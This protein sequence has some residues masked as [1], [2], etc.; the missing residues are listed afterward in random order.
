MARTLLM[1]PSTRRTVPWGFSR[2]GTC[3]P[4]RK[5]RGA[6]LLSPSEKQFDIPPVKS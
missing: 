3:C 1:Q 6:L 4:G 5:E 2:K